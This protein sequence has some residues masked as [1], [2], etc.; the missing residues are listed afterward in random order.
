MG[1]LR[2]RDAHAHD[3]ELL[4]AWARAMAW[5][6]ERKRLDPACVRAGVAA[7]IAD[8]A[9]ARYLVASEQATLAGRETVAVPVGTLRLTREW[10][11][12]RNGEW[13]WIRSAYVPPGHR[14]R[15]VFAA[16]YRHVEAQARAS[17]G[18]VG[19]RL[20]AERHDAAAQ[21]ACAALGMQDAGYAIFETAF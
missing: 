14:R 8:P 12:G 21:R 3:L 17:P 9:K 1:T 5:E 2:I 16:L 4:A 13:W 18:V 19:L 10:S 6:T 15:G 11:D 7:A 20:Y